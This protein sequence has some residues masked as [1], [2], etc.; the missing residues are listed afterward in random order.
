MVMYGKIRRMFYREHLS[1]NEIQRRTSL[2]RNTIK[3]WL[4]APS[5]SAMKY[6]RAKKL[7][8]LTAFQSRLLLALEADARRPKKDRRTALMLFKEILNAGYTGGYTIVCDFI[9]SWRNQGGQSKTAYV[10]LKFALGEAFQFDWSEEWLVIGGIHRKVLAAHTKL[11]ASRAFMLSGYPSQSHEMLFD[12][13]TRAFTA[14]GGVPKRGIYDNMKTAV[15]K[16]SKGNGRVVNT[17]F[18]AMTAHYLFDPD[19]CNVASGWEKGVV[20]KNVQDMRRRIWNKAKQ[21]QFGSFD[22][23]NRWLETRCRA[24]WS[25]IEHPDYAG[26][27]LAD[28][29]EQEQ[30]YLMPMPAPFD[31]YIEVLARVSSTC[32]V[33]LQRNRYSAP[34]RLVNQMVAVYQYAD[35]I[36]IVHDNAIAARHV[37]LL[38]RDQ[39]SYDWQHYIPVIEKK[40]GALRNGA[41]FAEL[42]ASLL[43]LQT[44]LRRRERQQAD[45]T[46]SKVLSLVPMHGLEA[47]LVAVDLVL[48]SDVISAEHVANVLTRLKHTDRPAPV[49]TTLKLKE[50]PQANTARYDRLNRQEVPHV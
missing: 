9:R 47:V 25:E 14:F 21:Q 43:K 4:K 20:E 35:H 37:R 49:E 46:M 16:V 50:E 39:V 12:A 10:P 36:E 19:F 44:A 33:T 7:G 13:H 23:L 1:I 42:P 8:K 27:T 40:P 11:C 6:Q 3:K 26:I 31:G 22:D 38:D 28:A 41:P 34:C 2:S 15:D 18:F 17:R 30:L 29:L 32:L 5:D 45:R 48:E 24:L